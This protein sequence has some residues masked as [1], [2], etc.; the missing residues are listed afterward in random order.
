MQEVEEVQEVRQK[1]HVKSNFQKHR[2]ADDVDDDDD[3]WP[4]DPAFK[5]RERNASE[6]PPHTDAEPIHVPVVEKKLEPPPEI[7]VVKVEEVKAVSYPPLP[8][9]ISHFRDYKWFQARFPRALPETFNFLREPPAA[10]VAPQITLKAWVD[11]M[12]SSAEVDPVTAAKAEASNKIEPARRISLAATVRKGS[13]YQ[14]TV[15]DAVGMLKGF[16]DIA[17][18]F[19]PSAEERDT[20]MRTVLNLMR[21]QACRLLSTYSPLLTHRCRCFWARRRTCG[22]SLSSKRS[23]HWS[24]SAP[25]HPKPL[26]SSWRTMC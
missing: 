23:R 4:K 19:D 2:P 8:R 24:C 21:E 20:I 17:R 22:G 9:Y 15:E 3:G 13:I 6:M 12:A 25:N 1:R 10:G 16:Q 5:P 18:D 7:V 14:S 11:F 26:W